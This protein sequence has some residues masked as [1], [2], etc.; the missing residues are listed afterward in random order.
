M[1]EGSKSFRLDLQAS[2]EVEVL[3][4]L[5]TAYNRVQK[6]FIVTDEMRLD[7]SEVVTNQ[8]T[9]MRIG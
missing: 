4:A 8:A 6:G 5:I 9:F 7:E 3:E 2:N 1:S